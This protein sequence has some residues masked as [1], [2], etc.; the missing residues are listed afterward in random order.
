MQF[1]NDHPEFTI[2]DD[3]SWIS[4][5]GYSLP[6]GNWYHLVG[7]YDGNFV[8]LYV[9]GSLVDSEPVSDMDATSV[10]AGIG[11]NIDE[12][13]RYF[14]GQIDELRVYERA[15]SEQEVED[16][17]KAPRGGTMTTDRESGPSINGT[18]V[19]LDYN[20]SQNPSDSVEVKV[21]ANYPTSPFVEE[22][23]WM[24]VPDGD[25]QLG[26]GGLPLR[27]ASEYRLKIR[28]NSTT[29]TSSPTIHSLE[30]RSS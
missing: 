23:A 10:D 11:S 29:R 27:N 13:G 18:D 28:M 9:N 4:A 30:V 25:S 24:S 7:V 22:S 19:V 3:G 26:V 8:R 6:V 12:G 15:L 2:H 5:E 1:N 20:T 16:L 14:D 17:H 21:V